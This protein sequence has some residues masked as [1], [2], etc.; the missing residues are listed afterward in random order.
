MPPKLS[1]WL[2]VIVRLSSPFSVQLYCDLQEHDK[3]VTKMRAQFEELATGTRVCA[4]ITSDVYHVHAMSICASELQTKHE[5]K[6]AAQREELEL[7][8]KTEIHEVEEVSSHH[9]LQCLM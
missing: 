9:L 2:V 5:R 1:R 7:R 8:R 4:S 6:M 3:A